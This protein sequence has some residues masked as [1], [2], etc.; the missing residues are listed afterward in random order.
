MKRCL[1]KATAVCAAAFV[2]L[3]VLILGMAFSA[4]ISGPLQTLEGNLLNFIVVMAA[5]FIGVSTFRRI[6]SKWL[7]E[8]DAKP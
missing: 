1:G 7:P 8:S 5:A 6:T 2:S 4:Q 3:V